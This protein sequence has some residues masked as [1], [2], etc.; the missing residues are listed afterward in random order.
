MRVRVWMK[1]KRESKRKRERN[2]IYSNRVVE[3]C[4]ICTNN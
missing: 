3:N 1:D 2:F 4:S